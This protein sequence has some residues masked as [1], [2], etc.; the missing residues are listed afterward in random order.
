MHAHSSTSP[1][2]HVLYYVLTLCLFIYLSLCDCSLF[3]FGEALEL[4]L[5]KKNIMQYFFK[6]FGKSP[7]P[8]C[9]Q[10]VAIHLRFFNYE[11][12]LYYGS[13]H[14][15][16]TF[17]LQPPLDWMCAMCAM[18]ACVEMW[19]LTLGA[20]ACA[21]RIY[22]TSFVCMSVCLYVCLSVTT[23]LAHLAA[24][25]LK[26]RHRQASNQ[27]RICLNW[28][29]FWKRLRSRDNWTEQKVVTHFH[30]LEWPA[31]IEEETVSCKITS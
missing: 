9:C 6:F 8:P 24:K 4:V 27:T 2:R 23:S 31:S 28:A 29:N 3:V 12:G 26:F 7:L 17:S 19:L 1:W 20:H 13:L 15:I 16:R 14:G 30:E 25:S 5:R 21:A 10:F 22:S 11:C 18:C